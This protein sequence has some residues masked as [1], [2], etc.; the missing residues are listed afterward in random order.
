MLH[1]QGKILKQNGAAHG[2]SGLTHV[3]KKKQRFQKALN[4]GLGCS[5]YM[6]SALL[7]CEVT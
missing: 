3:A 1:E 5:Y 4:L 6:A 7:H 2:S